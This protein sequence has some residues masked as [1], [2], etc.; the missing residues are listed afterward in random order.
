MKPVCG[1]SDVLIVDY[2]DR[3]VPML[4]RMF[5]KRMRTYTALGYEE[6]GTGGSAP[7]LG[8]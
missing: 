4:E 8:F 3:Q 7:T 2:I 5:Q 1:K 6:T